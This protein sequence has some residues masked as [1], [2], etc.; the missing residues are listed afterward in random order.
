[1]SE[2][3]ALLSLWDGGRCSM[4]ELAERVD[5]SRAAMTTLADR[6][7]RAGFLERIPDPSD[8]RRVLLG[9]TPKWEKDLF[10]S[11][12][13]LVEGARAVAGAAQD[14]QAS[15]GDIARLRQLLRNDADRLHAESPKRAGNR[16]KPAVVE[17]DPTSYW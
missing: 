7:E 8:R 13:G 17:D 2:L 4:S 12:S 16:V 3:H 1:M 14:W 15:A 9:V 11:A 10:N 5:L 6:I